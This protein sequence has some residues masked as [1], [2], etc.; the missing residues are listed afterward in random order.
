M[1]HLISLRWTHLQAARISQLRHIEY[2]L[3][4]LA[5]RPYWARILCNASDRRE[6]EDCQDSLRH[7]FNCLQLARAR[8]NN[9]SSDV[10]EVRSIVSVSQHHFMLSPRSA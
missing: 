2:L 8:L 10:L 4:N 9:I 1:V 6:I 7:A 3:V 5:S